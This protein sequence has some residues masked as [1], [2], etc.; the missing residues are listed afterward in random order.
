MSLLLSGARGFMFSGCLSNTLVSMIST[1]CMNGFLSKL[2]EGYC[3][4]NLLNIDIK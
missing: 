2:V 1:E 4:K 3:T